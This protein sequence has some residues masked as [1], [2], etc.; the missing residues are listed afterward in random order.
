MSDSDY[1]DDLIEVLRNASMELM[2]SFTMSPAES[3][4]DDFVRELQLTCPPP[5]SCFLDESSPLDLEVPPISLDT[6]GMPTVC[7]N[8]NIIEGVTK[9][10]R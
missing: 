5:L 6:S 9:S 10:I 2:S 1:E 3:L 8:S 4:N 7:L